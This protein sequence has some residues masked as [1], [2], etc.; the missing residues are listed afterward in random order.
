[1]G[2]PTHWDDITAQ[3][4]SWSAFGKAAGVGAVAGAAGA[5]AG[6]AA[7]MGG[8]A[9]TT[10][11]AASGVSIGGYTLGTTGAISGAISGAVSYPIKAIGNHAF[12]GDNMSGTEWGMEIL[13]G[14]IFGGAI[15]GIGA[16]INKQ[17]FWWGNS[18]KNPT[19]T[20][21]GIIEINP[22]FKINEHIKGLNVNAQSKHIP[23][24]HNYAEGKSILLSDPKQLLNKIYTGEYEFI[25]YSAR[26]NFPVV[27]FN[28]PVGFVIGQGNSKGIITNAVQIHFSAR[29]GLIHLSV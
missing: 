9:F 26:N 7:V 25:R 22:E 1:M 11:A 4:F 27:K 19:V 12:F 6:T 3:G 28:H 24:A 17:S 5:V 23:G 8:A 20:P 16:K 13:G 29:N 21:K 15:G 18:T 14:G 10:G 2:S